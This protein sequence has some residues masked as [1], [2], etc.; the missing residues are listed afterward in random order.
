[1]LP[2]PVCTPAWRLSRAACPAPP[3]S[4]GDVL[5]GGTRAGLGTS[6]LRTALRPAPSAV[7]VADD[8]TRI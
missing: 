8:N 4:I 1:M 7:G 2:A 3:S 5:P 6:T